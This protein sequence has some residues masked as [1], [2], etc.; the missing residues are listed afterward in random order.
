MNAEISL[1]K[2]YL[3]LIAWVVLG[4]WLGRILPRHVPL[5]LGKGL[6]WVGVPISIF[7]FLRQADLTGS[8]WVAPVV[9]WGAVALGTGLGWA[10]LRRPGGVTTAPTQGSFLLSTMVGNTG[11]L[12]YPVTLALVGPKYF[13]WALFYDTLG[14]TLAAYGLGV[15]IASAHSQTRPRSQDILRQTLTNPGLLSFGLGLVARQVE[16][17]Q[18]VEQTLRVIAWIVIALSLLLLGM[19]LGQLTSWRSLQLASVGLS[20]KMVIVPLVL[21]LLLIPLKLPAAAHLVIVMQM[22]MPPA[23]A[24]LVLTEAFD[25]DR[26]LIVTTLALGSIGVLLTLPLWVTLFPA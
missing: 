16:F 2:L 20:I 11:Y 21:G 7:T 14:S 6:F 19:R 22:G 4:V 25:L 8:V 13:A 17:P 24:T 23:F 26:E 3:P 1:A 5:A 10:W 15:A 18:P 12:G 9:A